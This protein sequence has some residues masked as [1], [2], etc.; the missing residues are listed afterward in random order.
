MANVWFCSD[1]HFGHK[2]IQ[3]FRHHIKDEEDNR[4]KI[5][6]DWNA[7]VTK[8]DDVYVL[9]DA[10]FTMGTVEEFASLPGARKFLVRGNHDELDTQVYLKYFDAV[11]GLKKYKEFWLSHAP[12]HPAELRGK[13]NL[14]GHVHY[15]TI[16]VENPHSEW[17]GDTMKDNR[18]FNCCVENVFA[19]KGRALISLQEIRELIGS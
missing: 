15:A 5:I 7:V 16:Q 18:Y 13:I 10:A 8:R 3:K 19:L 12:I 14:H 6:Q 1:L 4:K 17:I 9:G 11:Y 2:N